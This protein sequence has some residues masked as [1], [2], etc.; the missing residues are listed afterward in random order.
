[1]NESFCM[2]LWKLKIVLAGLMLR[3]WKGKGTFF[4]LVMQRKKNIFEHFKGHPR[5]RL[6]TVWAIASVALCEVSGLYSWPYFSNPNPSSRFG[7]WVFSLSHKSVSGVGLESGLWVVQLWE[8]LHIIC[9][10]WK[11]TKS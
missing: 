1:M 5:Q 7:I 2:S 8:F 6:W 11:R 4:S 10:S 9:V 3:F